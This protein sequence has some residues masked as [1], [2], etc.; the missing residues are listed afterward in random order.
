V[1]FPIATGSQLDS[2]FNITN[3]T[4]FIITVLCFRRR[5]KQTRFLDTIGLSNANAMLYSS[6]VANGDVVVEVVRDCF[7]FAFGFGFFAEK[8]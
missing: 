2:N 4:S 5:Q 8:C 1:Y 7:L 3:M 6:A